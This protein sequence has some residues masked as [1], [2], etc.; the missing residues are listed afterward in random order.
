MNNWT[1]KK[2]N[3]EKRQSHVQRKEKRNRLIE[4]NLTEKIKRKIKEFLRVMEVE[5]KRKD[6]SAFFL[7]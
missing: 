7:L 6:N 5:K 4:E 1:I 2:Q 3:K